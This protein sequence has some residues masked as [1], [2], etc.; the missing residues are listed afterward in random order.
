MNN[1]EIGILVGSQ[2][3]TIST[4]A[5]TNNKK[6]IDYKSF[7]SSQSVQCGFSGFFPLIVVVLVTQKLKSVLL[8][9]TPRK[10]YTS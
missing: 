5:F 9:R 3:N 4:N 6:T 2:N 1:E 8:V 7:E 10:D